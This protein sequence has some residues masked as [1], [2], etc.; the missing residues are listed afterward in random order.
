MTTT[1]ALLLGM[2]ADGYP[3]AF[4]PD[5]RH[6]ASVACATT[7]QTRLRG[8]KLFRACDGAVIFSQMLAGDLAGGRISF[9]HLGDQLL[10]TGCYYIHT[11]SFGRA[12]K[13]EH[14]SSRQLC[15]AIAGACS[16][17]NLLNSDD[18][19]EENEEYEEDEDHD[20]N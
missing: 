12:Y 4:A 8:L 19:E 20:E 18:E 14:P 6:V 16:W 2:P 7:Q 9:N 17:T 3:P 10:V 13:A 11:V 15:A 5:G 1:C